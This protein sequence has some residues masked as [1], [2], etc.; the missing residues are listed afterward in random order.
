[1][2]PQPARESLHISSVKSLPCHQDNHFTHSSNI[3]LNPNLLICNCSQRKS[4]P[5]QENFIFKLQNLPTYLHL[6][7]CTFPGPLSLSRS[8][9]L[10]LPRSFGLSFDFHVSI[11]K[12][13]NQKTKKIF[14]SHAPLQIL[15]QAFRAKFLTRPVSIISP[16]LQSF[17]LKLSSLLQNI[18]VSLPMGSNSN[19][20][21]S[22]FANSNGRFSNLSI[23][24]NSI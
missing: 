23:H 2:G 21:F 13:I 24:C 20:Q 1:M 3:K 12:K 5:S 16:L 17:F 14:H 15:L 10:L 18:L 9:G 22:N 11:F 7:P 19:G 8:T 4:K 6:Y